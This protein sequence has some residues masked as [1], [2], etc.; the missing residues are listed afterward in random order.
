MRTLGSGRRRSEF[1]RLARDRFPSVTSVTT[2]R[3]YVSV[4]VTLGLV[5][6]RNGELLPTEEGKAFAKTAN[7]AILRRALIDHVYGVRELLEIVALEPMAYPELRKRLASRD[8]AWSNAMAVRYRIWW[9]VAAE[10]ISAERVSRAD[11][12]RVTRAGRACIRER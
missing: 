12:L 11:I 1:E 2:V 9:L 5:E 6:L 8:I 7:L 10:A 4:L 3:G